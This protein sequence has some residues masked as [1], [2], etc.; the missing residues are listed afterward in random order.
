MDEDAIPYLML[1]FL[2]TSNAQPSVYPPFPPHPLLPLNSVKHGACCQ[3]YLLP[4]LW[5]AHKKK[6][7]TYFEGTVPSTASHELFSFTRS[8]KCGCCD[9]HAPQEKTETLR[10][11]LTCL[12]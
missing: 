12:R 11:C 2:F 9:L 5:R 1:L 7:G 8:W 3:D 6:E 4:Y 10:Y